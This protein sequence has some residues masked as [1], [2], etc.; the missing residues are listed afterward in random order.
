MLH[1]LE[2]GKKF[3]TEYFDEK[4]NI[5]IGTGTKLEPGVV[6]YDNCEIGESCIIGTSAV[7]KPNTKIGDHSIFGTLSTTEGNVKIGSW[8][9]IHSQCHITWGMEIGDRVFIAPFFYTANTPKIS[10]GKF[11]YPNTTDDPR[12]APK[13]RDGVRIGENVGCAPGVVIGEDCLIDM[14]CLITKNIP[15]RSIVR[16]GKSVVG[17]I[18]GEITD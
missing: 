7:L 13:I 12:Y 11:G 5:R 2:N 3:D 16:A 15:P 6:I 10:H 4:S 17:K 1:I 9:T 18:I 8:T 14:C